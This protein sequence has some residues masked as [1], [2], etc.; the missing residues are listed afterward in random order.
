MNVNEVI[1]NI[2]LIYLGRK[3]GEYEVI[4][5]IDYVNMLQLIND[6][7]F[8]VFWIVIIWNVREFFEEIVEFQKSFQKKE[9]EFED[10]IKVGRIQLQDVFFVILGQEFGVYVQVI[11]CDRW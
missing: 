4:Y 10:V 7:Y 1:V 9:Y 11:L 3:F 8:I 5:F 2:V 6:V